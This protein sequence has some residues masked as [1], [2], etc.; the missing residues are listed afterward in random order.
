MFHL[1]PYTSIP[2]LAFY[3]FPQI[4]KYQINLTDHAFWLGGRHFFDYLYEFRHYGMEVSINKRG[5]DISQLILNQYYPWQSGLPFQGFPVKTDG[6]V[7]LLSGGAMYKIE[8]DDGMYYKL[9]KAILDRFPEV[10][11]FYAGEGNDAH[12]R[13]FIK[14]NNYEGRLILLGNRKDIDALFKECDIYLSTY[15]FGGGLMSQFAAINSKPILLY[16]SKDIEKL[17]CTKEYRPY[18]LHSMDDFISEAEMLIRNKDYRIARGQ[19]FKKLLLGKEDFRVK[20]QQTFMKETLRLESVLAE[21][22]DYEGFIDNYVERINNNSF[23]FIEK[24]LIKQ[25]IFTFKVFI[26]T[27]FQLPHFLVSRYKR[28]KIG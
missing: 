2:F 5:Y 12:L 27:C 19:F 11:M 18:A 14:E 20:F 10:V 8:G 9:V 22:I 16:K 4:I 21:G 26:N 17:I 24:L 13:H 28:K 25:K 23:G 15:P 3:P 7:I 6:K 1:T